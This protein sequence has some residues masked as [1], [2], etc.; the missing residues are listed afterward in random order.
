IMPAMMGN[1][2]VGIP[3]PSDHLH[4]FFEDRLIVVEVDPQ[5]FVLAPVIATPG[6]EIDASP[7]HEIEAGPLLGDPDRMMQW[8]NGHCRREADPLR[9]RSDESEREIG[10][11][12]YAQGGEMMLA[13]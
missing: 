2:A 13:D 3:Q 5:R 6:G 1:R 12:Q 8:Q 9:A 4:A 10:T 7:T 11:R